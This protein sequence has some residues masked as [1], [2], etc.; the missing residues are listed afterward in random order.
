M[1]TTTI[2]SFES[3]ESSLVARAE[4][5]VGPNICYITLKVKDGERTFGYVGVSA[6]LWQEF[7]QSPSKGAFFS[8]NIR[9]QFVG[10]PKD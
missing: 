1:D 10:K 3:P 9:H 5:H 6:S 2:Q 7:E 8:R 4:Y